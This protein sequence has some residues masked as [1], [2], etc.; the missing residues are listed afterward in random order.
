MK[1]A[2]KI[3][4]ATV[5]SLV[6]LPSAL[7]AQEFQTGYF[8]GGYNYAYRMN[9]SIQNE[10]NFFA[11]GI[12][13]V[14]L[15]LNSNIGISSLLYPSENGGPLKTIFHPDITKEQMLSGL[16]P[17]GINN[18]GLEADVNLLALGW[19]AKK[20]YYTFEVGVR[21]N[22]RVNLPNELFSF[23]KEASP[24][25]YDLSSTGFSSRSYAQASL[26]MSRN[27]SKKLTVGLR[28]KALV[29]LESLNLGFEKLD[30]TVGSDRWNI[31][32][33]GELSG[34]IG[35]ASFETDEQG[36][37]KGLTVDFSNISTDSFAGF[38]GAVDL[39]VTF[40][41]LDWIT[42][43]AAVTDLGFVKWQNNLY[44]KTGSVDYT[45]S[46]VTFDLSDD[47]GDAFDKEIEKATEA[48]QNIYKVYD[49][50]TQA[51][52][53]FERMPFMVNVG[54]EVRLPVYKR[55]SAGVLY[56]L[57]NGAGFDWNEGRV[58][59]NWSPLNFI[60]LS[61]ST[62]MSNFGQ[63]WGGAFSFHPGLLSLYF[64]FDALSNDVVPIP[65]LPE[66]IGMDPS[67]FSIIPKGE[68]D[69]NL[70]FGLQL[71]IGRKRLD[72]ARKMKETIVVVE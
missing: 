66:K 33:T 45:Y 50:S 35:V 40:H 56:S 24:G 25:T 20:S 52:A 32:S 34:S 28:L 1:K 9:P 63:S 51:E 67:K 47:S 61:G 29:G 14:G 5:F 46:G 44:A 11:T 8:L 62:G 12:G 64:G 55:L 37:V 23:L 65:Y 7:S 43:S 49:H 10:R 31:S 17:T 19:W 3:L 58:S 38:G 60:S 70:Y 68:L 18:I 71:S 2:Y 15:N 30:L 53:E 36:V 54:A 48:L 41:V 69:F 39:G 16:S 59:V 42:L 22:N 57:R 21:S 4:A 26:G 13:D 6:L 27:I 72:Y